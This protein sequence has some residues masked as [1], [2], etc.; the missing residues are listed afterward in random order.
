MLA[1]VGVR[2][3]LWCISQWEKGTGFIFREIFPVHLVSRR[4]LGGAPDR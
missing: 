2:A 1:L 3:S 4:V